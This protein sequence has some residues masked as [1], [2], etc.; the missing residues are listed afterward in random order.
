VSPSSHTAPVV[1]NTQYQG[2]SGLTTLTTA[3]WTINY[4][5]RGIEDAD[6]VYT[7]LGTAEYATSD[8][9]KASNTL[10]LL[11]PLVTSHAEFVGRIIIQKN[12]TT[13][14]IAESAFD[15]VF[16]T[17]T[18]ISDHGQ[19]SGLGD[20]DHTQYFNGTR[21]DT[22]LSGKDT[23]DVAE[24][25][26]LYYTDE[27]AQDSVGGILT[28]S[29]IYSDS[30]PSIKLS[31]DEVTPS[32]SK[33]YGTNAGGAKGYFSLPVSPEPGASKSFAIAMAIALG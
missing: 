29:I 11:P 32:A 24:G 21:V 33:Y 18:P 22:W 7:I 5:Y 15:T 3:F 30:D 16:Q 2:A 14:I 10:S 8:L 13:G 20:D 25:T 31:G 19:L 27:R 17:A 26:N 6:H 12:A 4:V 9:A 1:N 23:D 28:G